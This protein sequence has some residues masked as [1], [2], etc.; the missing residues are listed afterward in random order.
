[1][2][3]DGQRPT[4][5]TDDLQSILGRI[6]ASDVERIEVIRGGA[7]GIDM[8]G[9]TVVAN[10]IR[11]TG[12]STQI[13]VDVQDNIL[14]LDGH[15]V[16]SASLEFT[17]HSGDSTYEGSICPLIGNFDNSVGKG[18]YRGH[19]HRDR[20]RSALMHASHLGNGHRLEP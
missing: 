4:A 7:P 18:F 9:H 5:K 11:K 13:V 1:M 17:R 10:V 8:Q 12:N 3:I 14:L 15:A 6:P 19:G 2:L 16:P 20:Y